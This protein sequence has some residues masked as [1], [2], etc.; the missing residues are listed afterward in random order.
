MNAEDRVAA[1]LKIVDEHIRR[2]NEHDLSG[3]MDT[4]GATARFDDEPFDAHHVGHRDVRAFYAGLLQALPS[5]TLD[6][7]YR[8]VAADTVI[9]EVIVRGLHLGPWRGLPPTG[10]QVEL[11]LCGIFTFD[12][13]NR[14]AGERAYYDRATLLRQL[15]IFHEPDSAIGR[16]A[17]IAMHPSTMMQVLA[18]R[19]W[20]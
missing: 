17:T 10:R 11:P 18:R 9:L 4:F 19:I 2:E 7:R 13:D 15:G 8:H 20:K 12:D 14:L 16:I 6:V 5:L 3:I 1:R